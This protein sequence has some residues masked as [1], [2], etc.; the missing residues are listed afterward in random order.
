MA[1]LTTAPGNMQPAPTFTRPGSMMVV[2]LIGRASAVVEGKERPLKLE[3]RLRHE[4]SF[5]TARVSAVTVEFST[6][7]FV[8]LGSDTELA[9]EEFWQQP[10]SQPGK[11]A[12]WKEEPSPSQ[13]RLR[14]VR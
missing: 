9:V 7:A 2:D 3:E 8:K 11:M 12:E 6:G 4:I 10:H 13:T 1:M 5:R 14:L